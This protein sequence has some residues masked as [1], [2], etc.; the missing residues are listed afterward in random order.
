MADQDFTQEKDL[1]RFQVKSF[2]WRQVDIVPDNAI[3]FLELAYQTA[4]AIDG[5][6]EFLRD[7]LNDRAFEE[8][9]IGFRRE[10]QLIQSI[11]LLASSLN[12]NICGYADSI[13]KK[14]EA[15]QTDK[16]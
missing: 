9:G 15:L 16:K 5:L 6:A 10:D 13:D 1:S 7:S 8:T 12:S 2:K 14:V 3:N 11:S 4:Y